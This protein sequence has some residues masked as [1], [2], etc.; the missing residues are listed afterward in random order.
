MARKDSVFS[1]LLACPSDVQGEAGL[2]RAAVD[3]VNRGVGAL[4]GVRLEVV[5]WQTHASPGIGSDVQ[6][7]INRQLP[8]CDVFLGVMWARFGTPTPRAGSGTEEEFDRALTRYQ[9]KPSGVKI[10]FYFKEKPLAPNAIEPAQLQK[11]IAFRER[12]QKEGVLYGTFESDVEFERRLR[13]DLGQ[14]LKGS[15]RQAESQVSRLT[16]APGESAGGD[17]NEQS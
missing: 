4:Q 13:Q 15:R 10:L 12:L 11:V 16:T 17:G 1:V 6:D 9:S 7:V 2:V 8:D 14:Q 5:D 3:E